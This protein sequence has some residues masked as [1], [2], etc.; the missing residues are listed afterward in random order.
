MEGGNVE[1]ENNRKED[2]ANIMPFFTTF[3]KLLSGRLNATLDTII[4]FGLLTYVFTGS[5]T[6]SSLPLPYLDTFT[7][8]LKLPI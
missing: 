3:A 7:Q 8:S 5:E 2:K 6:A 4:D 1:S